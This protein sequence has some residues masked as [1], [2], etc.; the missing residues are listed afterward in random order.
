MSDAVHHPAHYT[1]GTIETIDYI[2]DTLTREE[3]TGFCIGNSLKYLSRWRH[4]GGLEDL[5]KARVYLGWAIE[6]KT[7]AQEVAE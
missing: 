3:F 2:R 6:Q 1:R 7:E 4:K 5:E